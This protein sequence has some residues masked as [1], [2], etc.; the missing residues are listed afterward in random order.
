MADISDVEN[1]LVSLIEQIAYPSGTANPSVLLDQNSNPVKVQIYRG[2]P[3]PAQ[4]DADMLAGNIVDVSI[5]PT[6]VERNTTR[7]GSDYETQSFPAAT[8][9]LVAGTTTLT[10]GGTISQ[11]QN[12]AAI[13]NG[14]GYSYGVQANDTLTSIA[15]GLAALINEDT[16]CTSSGP[17]I[18]IPTANELIPRIGVVGIA[19]KEVK[20]QTR[21]VMISFWC[22]NPALRDAAGKLFD[23]ALA[24]I[25]FLTLTDSTACRFIYANSPITDQP[26]KETVYRRDL[27][28]SVEYPTTVA[29]AA[30]TVTIGIINVAD[31]I[32]VNVT[33]GPPAG[34]PTET[35]YI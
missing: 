25:E 34:S 13:V 29:I 17:V 35:T 3:I 22:P 14:I 10:V 5:F 33:G 20:R 18:T 12:V 23:P 15:T 2:W 1:A 7:Y 31:V 32:E 11:P 30:P 6:A 16:A 8:L 9:T 26:E 24:S 27:V 21:N 19:Y 28:Y 4:L